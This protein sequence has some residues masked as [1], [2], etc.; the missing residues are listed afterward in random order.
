MDVSIDSSTGK[1]QFASLAQELLNQDEPGL[2]NQAIM[3]FGAMHC[4]PMRP[5]CKECPLQTSCV[6]YKKGLVEKLPVRTKKAKARKRYF[7]YLVI[8][9]EG[10][11]CLR[12]RGGIGRTE[13]R[14]KVG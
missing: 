6:A 14:E 7:N 5:L 9:E 4:R 13:G 11:M 10:N 2:H 1:K 3:E 8:R 12:K